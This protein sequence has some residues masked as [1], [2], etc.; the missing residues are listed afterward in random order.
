M[1]RDIA[2]VQDLLGQ[3][4]PGNAR[5]EGGLTLVPYF[6]SAPAKDYLLASEALA[7]GLL[8][9]GEVGSG[10]V[11]NVVVQNNADLPA[12]LLDGEHL[13]GARQS[14]ILNVSALLPA[15]KG[16]VLPVS[17][18]E[19]GRWGYT[20]DPDF[21]SSD[22]HAYSRLRRTQAEMAVTSVREGR[23][24]RPNQ[25]AVWAEVASKHA[26]T[27]TRSDTGAMR[28]SF[29]H[30]RHSLDTVLRSFASP[31]PGQTGVIA[32]IGG[33]PVVMDAFDRPETLEKMWSR[34]ISGYALDS[35]GVPATEPAPGVVEEF[36]AQARLGEFSG[37]QGIGLGNDV[38]VTSRSV[39][40]SALTW[41]GGIVHIG[42]FG[43][44]SVRPYN[45]PGGRMASP[46]SR[47]RMRG[48]FH[49]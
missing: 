4:Q 24:R 48:Y 18:V 33:E 25:V 3:M 32:C 12:L 8:K 14:R 6:A 7:Q 30:Q 16:T 9:I 46:R 15:G 20:G 11:P 27:G 40:G 41:E 31:E 26:Q 39:V 21:S 38:L 34:L 5:S 49:D 35:I 17:C 43:R 37:H 2:L 42:L 22:H 1:Q 28:D 45:L 10:E 19:Q 29:E 44:T 23:E 47:R 36:V 13:E